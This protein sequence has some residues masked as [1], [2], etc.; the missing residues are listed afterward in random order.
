MSY[1]VVRSMPNAEPKSYKMT[2]SC[3]EPRLAVH[4]SYIPLTTSGDDGLWMNVGTT[5]YR[6]MEYKSTSGANSSIVSEYRGVSSRESVYS[7]TST[8]SSGMSNVT[9]LPE[10][11]RTTVSTT[12]DLIQKTLYQSQTSRVYRIV[13]YDWTR[14]E[15]SYRVYTSSVVF[16]AYNSAMTTST[17]Q[18][19]STG[20]NQ[21]F[22]Q[23]EI[24]LKNINIL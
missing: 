16:S 15:D 20:L 22:Q 3:D 14:T 4:G 13:N 6:V 24:F 18:G 8:D 5:P 23:S 10:W 21:M 7:T 19:V 2:T 12:S 1:Y 17:L 9:N 11:A